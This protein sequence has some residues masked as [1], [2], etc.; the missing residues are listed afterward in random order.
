MEALTAAQ[1]SLWKATCLRPCCLRSEVRRLKSEVSA[2][3]VQ[4]H[5]LDVLGHG[6]IYKTE[7]RLSGS[8]GRADR[9]R[10]NWLMYFAQQMNRNPR[11]HQIPLRGLFLKRSGH[12]RSRAQTPRQ[13]I[14]HVS[15]RIARAAGHD[16]FAFAKQSLGLMPLGNVSEG[17]DSEQEKK[18]VAFLERLL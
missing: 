13:R 17:V 1:P 3:L 16:E 15:Q 9:G 14:G 11:Q 7:K 6:G 8:G 2:F 18:L 10:R 12:F 5:L 4:T